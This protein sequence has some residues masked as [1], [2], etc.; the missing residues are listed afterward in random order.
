MWHFRPDDKLL[1]RNKKGIREWRGETQEFITCWSGGEIVA[2]SPCGRW[3]VA[4]SE[5]HQHLRLID[6]VA[7][8]E[9][10]E[11]A[12]T[13]ATFS[14]NGEFVVVWKQPNKLVDYSVYKMGTVA[15]GLPPR[16]LRGKKTWLLPILSPDG[17][18]IVIPYERD[19]WLAVYGWGQP[20]PL[21]LRCQNQYHCGTWSPDGELFVSGH[22][23]REFQIRLASQSR[24]KAHLQ[25]GASIRFRR[26]PSLVDSKQLA[27][28][29]YDGTA[30][31]YD[32]SHFHAAATAAN[33]TTSEATESSTIETMESPRLISSLN[34]HVP[35]VREVV[36]SHDGS[37]LVTRDS[38]GTAKMW[39]LSGDSSLLPSI[40]LREFPNSGRVITWWEDTP[41]GIATSKARTEVPNMQSTVSST[42]ETSLLPLVTRVA[43]TKSMS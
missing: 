23:A 20:E 33:M 25:V 1:I 12:G 19:Q 15:D 36:F 30:E 22:T 14:A 34:A 26:W 2:L 40:A 17:K 16:T 11:V 9:I 35:P 42:W 37:K 29:C 10:R 8:K 3:A 31:V 7:R 41:E 18:S 6:V 4:Q 28:G 21:S 24:S 32:V 27:I 5:N 43:S 38:K 13:K 39:K